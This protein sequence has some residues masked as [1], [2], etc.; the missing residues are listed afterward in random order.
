MPLGYRALM[1]IHGERPVEV[2]AREVVEEWLRHKKLDFRNLE[3]GE[4]KVGRDTRLVVVEHHP[5]GE[6]LHA[7]RYRLEET[8]PGGVRWTTRLT[9]A[10]GGHT[11][12][13][14][15]DVEAPAS[16]QER[17]PHGPRLKMVA[18]PRLARNI[19]SEVQAT[20]GPAA[21][22][23]VPRIV[24]SEDE[25]D[26]LIKALVD[27]NRHVPVFV[28]AHVSGVDPEKW[29]DHVASVLSDTTGMAAAYVL[30]PGT[31]PLFREAVGSRYGIGEGSLR[32]YLPAVDLS[33]AVDARR[34]RVLSVGAM[35]SLSDGLLQRLV[36]EGALRAAVERPL[37]REAQRLERL[38]DREENRLFSEALA[39]APVVPPL[40]LP[41]PSPVSPAALDTFTA[42]LT[43]ILG[44]VA[45]SPDDALARVAAL[46]GVARSA[47]AQ[48]APQR[49]ALARIN[50]LQG[51]L[52]QA[53]DELVEV[54]TLL[55]DEKLDHA[56]TQD[57]LRETDARMA[58]LRQQVAPEQRATVDSAVVR[59]SAAQAPDS[60]AALLEC[61]QDKQRWPRV[62]YTGDHKTTLGL[63]AHDDVGT[64][65]ARV[66]DICD[67]LQHFADLVC[68]RTH[69]GSLHTYLSS[70]PPG[71]SIP[72]A[73]AP[74]KFVPVESEWVANNTKAKRE[75]TLPVPP[76][77][78]GS[79]RAF[80][81]A[82]YRIQQKGMISPR[83]YL[84]DCTVD[85]GY[86]VVGYIG[87]HLTNT[88][89]S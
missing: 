44:E 67:T 52:E 11:S 69:R 76:E 71:V 81:Q 72:S 77:V 22:G 38:L 16:H 89:T 6:G 83:L 18:V 87:P 20:D 41:A 27:P 82:H 10:A 2:L 74:G 61:F 21:L 42:R 80:M 5:R 51:D 86:V 4:H 58:V 28:A 14:W 62:I 54:R 85:H 48:D 3:P 65:A 17:G 13:L 50:D 57:E 19:L 56:V 78:T 31:A 29:R 64:W 75:R 40:D 26:D 15:L 34:H 49:A 70:P 45:L 60:M 88:K 39:P 32:T 37:P 36:W 55:E 66:S 59:A 43:T 35:V 7:R 63:Q 47:A 73:A 23:P 24:A 33:D 25:V 79:P 12:L 53:Q 1:T 46:V 30:T 8:K 68:S 9:H 84:L